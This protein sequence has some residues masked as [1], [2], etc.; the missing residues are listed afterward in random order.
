MILRFLKNK[1]RVRA[2]AVSGAIGGLMQD[3]MTE[4]PHK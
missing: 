2:S 4:Q 3:C 1:V